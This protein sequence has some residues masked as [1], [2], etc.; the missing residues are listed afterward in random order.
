MHM[1]DTTRTRAYMI[2]A[3][4]APAIARTRERKEDFGNGFEG[5]IDDDETRYESEDEDEYR[6]KKTKIRA[7]KSYLHMRNQ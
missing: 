2:G 6:S 3:D 7:R 5:A 1:D 4:R